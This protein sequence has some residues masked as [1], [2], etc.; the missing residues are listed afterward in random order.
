MTSKSLSSEINSLLGSCRNEGIGTPCLLGTSYVSR[1]LKSRFAYP[2]G[3]TD[4]ENDWVEEPEYP[5]IDPETHQWNA[6]RRQRLQA[7]LNLRAKITNAS[8]P[9]L[10][11]LEWNMPRYENI[12]IDDW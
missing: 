8:C 4:Y 3:M 1:R 11:N 5:R 6:H 12:D 10:K 7:L 2:E 9:E